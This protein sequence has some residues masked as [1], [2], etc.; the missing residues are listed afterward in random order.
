MARAESLAKA[1][2]QLAAGVSP[3]RALEFL[4]HTLTNRLLH[5]PTVALRE[6]ALTGDAELARAAERMFP[7]MDIGNAEPGIEGA[8]DRE[9]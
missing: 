5:A 3:E 1:R 9:R 8:A 6:A 2:Q 7:A 4:A